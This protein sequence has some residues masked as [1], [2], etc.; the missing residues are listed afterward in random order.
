MAR[1]RS[2]QVGTRGSRRTGDTGTTTRRQQLPNTDP[3]ARA[4]GNPSRRPYSD[5]VLAAR[6]GRTYAEWFA[7]LDEWGGT[8]RSHSEIAQ[9]LVD[10]HGVGGWWAQ[11]IA[12]QYE[13]A[14]GMRAPGQRWDGSFAATAAKTIA[15]SVGR[16]HHAFADASARGQWLPDMNL[17]VRT[18]RP[19]KSLRADCDDGSRIEVT[20]VAQSAVKCQVRVEHQR[21]PDAAAVP[22]AKEF[23]RAR[24]A[25]LKEQLEG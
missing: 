15:A 16:V 10:E 11:G 19:G 7:L 8:K 2:P 5:E 18:S 17:R 22:T 21:L 4:P 3:P 12:V 13:Q 6:T 14:R 9:M 20:F 24:L 23:W 1:Q 25:V